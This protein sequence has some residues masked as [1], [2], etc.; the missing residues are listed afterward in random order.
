MKKILSKKG[1]N[2]NFQLNDLKTTML[3]GKGK[4]LPIDLC[5]AISFLNC[6]PD[7]MHVIHDETI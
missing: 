6:S 1:V 7:R 4:G 5:I 3:D 2:L